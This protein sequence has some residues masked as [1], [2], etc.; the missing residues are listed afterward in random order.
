MK[1]IHQNYRESGVLFAYE[2]PHSCNI[3]ILIQ[4][5]TPDS[6]NILT[7]PRIIFLK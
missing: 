7:Y 5:F 1:S 2:K 3:E 4:T 6:K